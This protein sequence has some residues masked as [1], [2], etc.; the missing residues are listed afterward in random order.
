MNFK[1]FLISRFGSFTQR[2]EDEDNEPGLSGKDRYI[3]KASLIPELEDL[4]SAITKKG[5]KTSQ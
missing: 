2:E 3:H 5:E 1:T 4:K